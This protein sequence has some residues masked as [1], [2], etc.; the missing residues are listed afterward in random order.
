MYKGTYEELIA[1]TKVNDRIERV[2]CNIHLIRLLCEEVIMKFHQNFTGSTVHSE[3]KVNKAW[4]WDNDGMGTRLGGLSEMLHP[5]YN[6]L[7]PG[8][9]MLHPGYNMLHPG[10]NMLHPGYNM[11]HPGYNMLQGLL[12]SLI[13]D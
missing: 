10:Y 1:V 4:F 3:Q 7:H 12:L 5:G 11:L 9:N 8:Y 6:M 13:I 2:K